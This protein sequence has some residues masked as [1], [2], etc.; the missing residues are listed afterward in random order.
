[1]NE[2]GIRTGGFAYYFCNLGELDAFTERYGNKISNVDGMSYVYS[3]RYNTFNFIR[4]GER[5]IWQYGEK[6]YYI[7]IGYEVIPVMH[8]RSE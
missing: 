4:K 8:Q 1:M 6:E 2:M 5:Y 7:K 3:Y